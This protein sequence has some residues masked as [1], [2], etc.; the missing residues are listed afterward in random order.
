MATYA[1]KTCTNCG[2]RK[3][4]PEM[5]QKE[6]YVETGKSKTGI[7]GATLFGTFA[8]D[9]KSGTQVRNWLFNSGQRTYKRKKVVWLC[10]SCSGRAPLAN[11]S[12]MSSVKKWF[13]VA[14]AFLVLI[15]VFSEPKK[16]STSGTQSTTIQTSP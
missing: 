14:I 9:K 5:Y 2:I 4:Q 11:S 8:G 12:S 3:P 16:P 1:N 7:S 13:F 10:G 15:G 6:V